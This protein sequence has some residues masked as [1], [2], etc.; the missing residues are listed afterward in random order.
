MSHCPCRVVGDGMYLDLISCT[1][2]LVP[3]DLTAWPGRYWRVRRRPFENC[4]L[5][6]TVRWR[7]RDKARVLGG[8]CP[9]TPPPF[10]PSLLGWMDPRRIGQFLDVACPSLVRLVPAATFV[11]A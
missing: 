5:Q 6:T 2:P 8:A 11:A 9:H 1:R 4:A 3:R 10:H 7:C